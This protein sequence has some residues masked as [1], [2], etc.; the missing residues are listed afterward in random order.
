MV[1]AGN[2][3]P[4]AEDIAAV[5]AAVNGTALPPDVLAGEPPPAPLTKPMSISEAAKLLTFEHHTKTKVVLGNASEDAS[6]FP[7]SDAPAPAPVDF[8]DP[9]VVLNGTTLTSSPF[10]HLG[11]L[12]GQKHMCPYGHAVPR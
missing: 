10:S 11:S 9:A 7:V 1:N 4:A 2:D 3:L 6:T 5:L 12:A 8:P